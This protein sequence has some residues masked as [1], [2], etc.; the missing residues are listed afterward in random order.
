MKGPFLGMGWTSCIDFMKTISLHFLQRNSEQKPYEVN[1]P[2]C[3]VEQ[4]HFHK[5]HERQLLK[6]WVYLLLPIL[7][8]IHHWFPFVIPASNAAIRSHRSTGQ[9]RNYSIP[10]QA[11]L[12]VRSGWLL[13]TTTIWEWGILKYNLV[14]SEPLLVWILCSLYRPST[15]KIQNAQDWTEHTVMVSWNQCSCKRFPQTNELW[16]Y[17]QDWVYHLR[18]KII[19]N[20]N[21]PVA[22]SDLRSGDW[23][24]NDC[25]KWDT[26]VEPNQWPAFN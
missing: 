9:E 12:A 26:C 3:W 19:A 25:W 14:V 4:L 10:F 11:C 13:N 22:Y 21:H 1:T 23:L 24:T 2:W 6:I 7:Y 20:C 16:L 18:F 15:L 8:G 5:F 17:Y